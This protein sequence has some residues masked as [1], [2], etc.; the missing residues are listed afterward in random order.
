[1]GSSF[2]AV[3]VSIGSR[4]KPDWGKGAQRIEELAKKLP[5]KW[6]AAY[7]ENI[8]FT[9]DSVPK[10]VESLR[11][12]LER[13]ADAWSGESR[14]AGT[15]TCHGKIHFI[16]GGISWGDSPSE[17]YDVFCRLINAGVTKAC[18]FEA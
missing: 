17:M 5:H 7:T 2:C 18:G 12:D 13:F 3:M 14:E 16:S 9:R 4:K 8:V 15:I 11:A 6:P 10:E 1:M